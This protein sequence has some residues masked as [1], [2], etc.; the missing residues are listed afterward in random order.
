VDDVAGVVAGL[1]VTFTL[2][3]WPLVAAASIGRV[4]QAVWQ[5]VGRSKPAWFAAVLLLPLTGVAYWLVVRPELQR[6]SAGLG[7]AGA[8]PAGGPRPR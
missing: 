4:G 1:V 2:V 3:V 5:A 7:P 8:A 6:A